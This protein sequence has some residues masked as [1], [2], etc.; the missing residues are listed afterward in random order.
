MT[1]AIYVLAG[2]GALVLLI[3]GAL[4]LLSLLVVGVHAE[5]S[6]DIRVTFPEGFTAKDA[7]RVIDRITEEAAREHC[8]CQLIDVQYRPDTNAQED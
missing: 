1:T 7:D 8:D 5:Q 4:L 2:F 3:G 6:V